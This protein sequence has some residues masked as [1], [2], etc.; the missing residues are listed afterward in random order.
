[1]S[2][3]DLRARHDADPP[4][5]DECDVCIVGTGPAGATIARELSGTRLRVTL[6]ESGAEER[7]PE[8]DRLN[9]VESVGRPRT[10]DQWAVRNRIL[11]GS[12]HTWGGRCAPFDAIDFEKRP[13]VPASGWPF[14]L[15]DLT[16]YLD[17]SAAHLGLV[18]GSGFE[19]DRFWAVA[20][21]TPPTARPAPGT[22]LPFFWQFSRD[23]EE[24]YPYEYVR[25]GRGLARS[26]ASNVTLV[27][28]ATVVRVVPVGSADAVQSV[29]IAAPGGRRHLLRCSAVVLCTGGIENARILLSSATTAISS[30]ATSWTTR[31]GPSA[32]SRQRDRARCRSASAATTSVDTCSARAS[33]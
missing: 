1:M 30:G 2:I 32:P 8:S 3:I 5:L 24:S 19:D 4:Q 7:S 6:L 28:G 29:E 15:D 22:L 17:R 11:G 12:S 14:G 26:L 20:R 33:G 31:G 27:T 23:D 9:E 25:F 18:V 10:T 21:R 13:W 16:P